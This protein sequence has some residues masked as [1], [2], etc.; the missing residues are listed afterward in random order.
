MR[1]APLF[2]WLGT[3]SIAARLFMSA[4]FWSALILLAAGVTLSAIDRRSA[5][6]DFDQRLSVYV[7]ALAANLGDPGDENHSNLGQL[8]ET[9][10]ELPLSGWYWQITPL[11]GDPNDIRASRSLFAERLPRL[12]G[13]DV[14]ADLGGIRRGYVVGPDDRRLRLV[15]R[16]IETDD[17]HRY[18]VQVA[19]SPEDVERDIRGFDLALLVTLSGLAV[20]LVGSTVLQVRFGLRPLR[21]LGAGVAAIREGT[22]E[23]VEGAFPREIAPIANE[24]NL[25]I[26]ANREIVDRARTHVGNLA[27]ALKTPLSIIV[28]EVA[29][30]GPGELDV[31]E[32]SEVVGMAEDPARGVRR[33]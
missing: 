4:C 1:T 17:R 18:L 25:L 33:K 24:L 14:E 27:H 23:R 22:A 19:A 3:R 10:F 2:S 21:R 32:A 15:E 31:I 16:E 7:R 20:A 12:D 26:V 8:G 30:G 5:E 29:A 13:R 28:N 6:A 11:D 9:M